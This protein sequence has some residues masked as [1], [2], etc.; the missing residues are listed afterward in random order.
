MSVAVNAGEVEKTPKHSPSPGKEMRVADAVVQ[1]LA[2]CGVDTFYGIPGGAIAS[3]YDSCRSPCPSG[4]H[5]PPRD[6]REVFMAMGQSRV[7]GSLPCVLTTSGRGSPTPSPGSP[8]RTRMGRRC[9]HLRRGPEEELRRAPSRRG[10]ATTSMS[11]AWS[12][13]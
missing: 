3:V 10:A 11:S 6:R 8:L 2:D 5:H 4:H 7:G 12:G 9:R 1:T 13:A